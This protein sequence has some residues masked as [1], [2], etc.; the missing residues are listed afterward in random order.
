MR[1]SASV[2]L[3]ST[4]PRFG[5]PHPMRKI[6]LFHIPENGDVENVE[7]RYVEN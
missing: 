3:L 4:K 7:N 1:K 6:L 5:F 2:P